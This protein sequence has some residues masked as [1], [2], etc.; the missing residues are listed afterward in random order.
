MLKSPN[1]NFQFNIDQFYKQYLQGPKI[2]KNRDA[3]EAS[4]IPNELP[5][6]DKEIERVAELTACAL[7]YQAPS[8]FLCYGMTGTGKTATIRYVSQKLSQHCSEQK[9]WWIY[10]NCN[11]VSTPY[12]ILAHICNDIARKEIIPPTG[13]PKDIIFKELVALLD[14][15][16]GHAICFVVLD[17]IDVVAEKKEGNG[18]LYDLTRI[19][20]ELAN[21]KIC[22]IGISN[23]INFKDNL[24][25]RVK[26]SLGKEC[27][28]FNPY[29]ANELRDILNE[30]AKIA[31]QEGV[32]NED[33]IPLC[34][35]LATQSA[36]NGDARKALQLLRK[37]GEIA[38]RTQNNK[39]TKKHL[40]DAQKELDKDHKED[41]ILGLPFQTQLVLTAI[42]LLAKFNPDCV[43][44]SGDVYDVYTE[45][46]TRLPDIKQLGD[47][48]VA[49]HLSNLSSAG[50]VQQQVKSAGFYGRTKVIELD[51]TIPFLERILLKIEKLKLVLN[52]KPTLLQSDKV[53]LKNNVFKKLA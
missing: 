5:H 11:I 53:K 6:R 47:R 9:P 7:N 16:I 23:R 20:E 1:D 43:I 28:V 24:D 19:N 22:L 41:Y 25:E 14:N 3:L 44:I 38:E 37:A 40:D 4:F 32:I 42:Y 33:V 30:R 10:I 15:K 49:N 51:I 12:R 34:A 2:F 50:I 31:F 52:H 18:L 29:N 46:A 36:E 26:S 8:H 13:L 39:V 27:I 21:C 48:M 35:A 45:L 17:E